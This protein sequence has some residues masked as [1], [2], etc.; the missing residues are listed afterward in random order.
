LE[1][2]YYGTFGLD[3]GID[4]HMLPDVQLEQCGTQVRIRVASDSYLDYAANPH[5][6]VW[7]TSRREVTGI[8]LPSRERFTISLPKKISQA[9]N[10]L[11]VGLNTLYLGTGEPPGAPTP[12][13]PLPQD[14]VWALNVPTHPPARTTR[15]R[16]LAN[17]DRRFQR[18]SPEQAASSHLEQTG[19]P[20]PGPTQRSDQRRRIPERR[21]SL[22]AIIGGR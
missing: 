9:L 13:G 3:T 16:V 15:Q 12:P 14:T 8:W 10:L 6:V 2:R 20:A 19:P 22:G 11:A 17:P 18:V 5:L 21:W 4:A 7:Q 1:F